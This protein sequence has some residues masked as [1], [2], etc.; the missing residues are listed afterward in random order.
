MKRIILKRV[1]TNDYG[2]F[3]VL[4]YNSIPFAVTLEPSWR[5]NLPNVSCIPAETYHCI[6]YESKKF[7]ETF[8]VEGVPGRSGILFH[9]G[10]VEDDTRGCIL[11]GEEF[12][13]VFGKPGIKMSG[14]GFSEFKKLIGEDD[15]FVLE[16]RWC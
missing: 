14:D 2:T 9:K 4:I 15:E 6:R 7:G 12:D 8:L 11:V 5:D 10:N 13:P 16:V 3:G 1:A